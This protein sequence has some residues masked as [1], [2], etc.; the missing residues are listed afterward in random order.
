MPRQ[1]ATIE[2]KGWKEL[3]KASRELP[4]NSRRRA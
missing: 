4:T 1:G 3:V 2:V